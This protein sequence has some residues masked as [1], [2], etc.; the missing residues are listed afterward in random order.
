MIINALVSKNLWILN[1]FFFGVSKNNNKR[2]NIAFK[3][4]LSYS[5]TITKLSLVI[6]VYLD[7]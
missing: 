4:C 1:R 3:T 7:I 5:Q 2:I 6:S